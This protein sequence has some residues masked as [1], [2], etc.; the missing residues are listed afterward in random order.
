MRVLLAPR[1][2]SLDMNAME[3]EGATGDAEVGRIEG[4][5]S[6]VLR[7]PNWSS[8][9]DR[10]PPF[11]GPLLLHSTHFANTDTTPAWWRQPD[12]VYSMTQ[13][14]MPSSCTLFLS[15]QREM[16]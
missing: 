10:V 15:S 11:L 8:E 13:S 12:C 4:G 2:V 3:G 6:K 1:E 9:W 7:T 5:I 14:Q 16:K